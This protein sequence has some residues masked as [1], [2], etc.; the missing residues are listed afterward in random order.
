M[1][2][3]KKKKIIDVI[4]AKNTRFNDGVLDKKGRFLIGTMGYPEIKE[5]SGSLFSY[6][7]GKIDVLIPKVTISNGI[8]F[9]KDHKKMFYIDTPTRCVSLYDYDI[10][11]GKCRKKK[12]IIKFENDG[13]PDG[14]II[15]KKEYL[16]IAEYGGSCISIWNSNNGKKIDSIRLP[17]KNITSLCFDN[18]ND[19]FV[20]SAKDKKNQFSYIYHLKIKINEQL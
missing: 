12:E 13:V 20:S 2:T 15:D 5:F 16:W 6:Y 7:N 1:K 8:V 3:L 18:N 4:L 14:M 9:S 10:N 11:T 17:S 19:I